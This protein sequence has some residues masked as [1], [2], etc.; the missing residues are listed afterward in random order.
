LEK[1][2]GTN[3]SL[4][5]ARRTGLADEVGCDAIP[6]AAGGEGGHGAAR[7]DGVILRRIALSKQRYAE[8]APV[9]AIPEAKDWCK[10]PEEYLGHLVEDSVSG[11]KLW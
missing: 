3:A 5:L 1:R 7:P 10:S 6:N 11:L 2:R 9:L 8:K 4:Y